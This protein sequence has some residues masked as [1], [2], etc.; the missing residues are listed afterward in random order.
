MT[1]RHQQGFTLVEI[2]VVLVIIGLLLGAVLKGQELIAS[3]RVSNLISNMNGYKAAINAFEDRYRIVPGDSST[4]ATKVGN[5][6]INCTVSC[7]DG[8]IMFWW[9]MNLANNHLLAAGFY[10]GPAL[11]YESNDIGSSKSHLSNPGGGPIFV[12]DGT[13]FLTSTGAESTS[14]ARQVGTGW[15]LSSKLLGEVDRKIDDGNGWTGGV[16]AGVN[17]TPQANSGCVSASTG[18]WI[19]NNPGTN[20]LAVELFPR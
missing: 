20:C 5:G 15:N 8:L 13:Y 12:T 6:A 9:N 4:A 7:D 3:A 18:A 17:V 1:R 14:S 19:E 2:G 10:S 11:P 16:R